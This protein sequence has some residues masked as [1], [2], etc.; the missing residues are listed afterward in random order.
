[1]VTSSG[2]K[3]VIFDLDGTLVD[4][5]KRDY[6]VYVDILSEFSKNPLS[7]ND[8]WHLKRL[9]TPIDSVLER[10]Q[11]TDV[12]EQFISRRSDLIENSSYL[13]MDSLIPRAK[14]VLAATWENYEPWIVT[15]R[16]NAVTTLQQCHQLG[17]IR[18]VHGIRVSGGDKTPV[19]EQLGNIAYVIGDT[20][21]DILPARSLKIPAIAV[22]SGIRTLELLTTFEPDFLIEDIRGVPGI[23]SS[24]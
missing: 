3:K 5:C 12:L 15:A 23:L 20:E 24:Q 1:M 4:V 19:F 13:T 9:A 6:Q 7:F 8:Y 17:L 22:T 2:R 18:L 11:A 10:S 16:F 14:D 21:K